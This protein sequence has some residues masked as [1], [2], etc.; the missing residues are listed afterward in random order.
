[1]NR[2][3]LDITIALEAILANKVKTILT[4]LGIIFG[5]AAVITMLAI[6]NGARQEILN[7]MKMVGVNNIII[8]PIIESNEEQEEDDQSQVKRFS[9]GLALKDV[10]SI[11]QVLP[12]VEQVCPQVI[13]NKTLIR[14]GKSSRV[15]VIGTANNYFTLFNKE[16]SEGSFF[17]AHQVEYGQPVCIVTDQIK[18]S[19]FNNQSPI[20]KEIKCGDIWLRV[21]GVVEKPVLDESSGELGLVRDNQ[22]VYVPVQTMLLRYVNRSLVTKSQL[23]ADEDEEENTSAAEKKNYNQLDKVIV[24]VNKSENLQ[25]TRAVLAK[26][27]KRLHN[28]VDDFEIIVPELLLQQQQK[29]RDI[30][31]LVLGAIAGISLLV[32]GIGIMNIMLA[33]V[34][35][36]FKE[37]GI[38][39]AVGARKKD[40]LTQFVAEAALISFSGGIIG[41]MLGIISSHFVTTVTGIITIVSVWSVIISFGIS[42]AIGII[43]GYMPAR[44]AATQD[45]IVS[46]RSE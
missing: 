16:L 10:K 11:R 41:V 22:V 13:Q 4:A 21:V 14:Q 33:T 1:M 29:T 3:L 25:P 36:R 45:P 17:N 20:G 43:F 38:R 23:E 5:V 15:K 6:G 32:G 7:Q 46:L 18:V 42:V 35:E 2:F 8:Q 26:M 30:F 31:N 9:P 37:I 40:I 34:M 27:L 28:D 39:M 24:Q 44:K 19:I 12:S